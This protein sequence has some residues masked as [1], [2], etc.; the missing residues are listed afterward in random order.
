M[1]DQQ[2]PYEQDEQVTV[3]RTKPPAAVFML[4]AEPFYDQL[5][6]DSFGHPRIPD[7][8][9]A[10][11]SLLPDED[12][13]RRMAA[14]LAVKL[15]RRVHVMKSIASCTPPLPEPPPVVWTET[16]RVIEVDTG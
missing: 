12:T 2:H 1:T 7:S 6:V 5:V 13:A 16:Q 11:R 14:S 4:F 8:L 3:T 10:P 9:P 15:K